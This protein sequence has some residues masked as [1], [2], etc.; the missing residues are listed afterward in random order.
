MV[1]EIKWNKKA[2]GQLQAA[3]RYGKNAFGEKAANRFYQKV[4]SNESR[5]ANNPEL[6]VVE[7][8]LE[9][10]RRLYRSL[11]VHD[12]YKLIYHI[13]KKKNIIYISALWDT[14]SNPEKLIDNV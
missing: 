7:P 4:I 11:V 14:R 3:L 12:R 9:G 6:G 1:A 5:L 13:D 10:C 8:L 2:L